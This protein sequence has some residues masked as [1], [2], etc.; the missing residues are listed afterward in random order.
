[1]SRR[2]P[3]LL[4]ADMLEAAKKILEYTY[5]LLFDDFMSDSK[6]IDAV[7]RNFEII[8]EAATRLPPEFKTL[9]DSIPW[10]KIS[11]LRNRLIHDYFGIDYEVVWNIKTTFLPELIEK[12]E[13]IQS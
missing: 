8:G 1:M 13:K 2:D 9:H 5:G 3:Q 6:T 11:G 4:V 12:L 7:V 10:R